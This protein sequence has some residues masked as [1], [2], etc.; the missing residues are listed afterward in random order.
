MIAQV[1]IPSQGLS[2][3]YYSPIWLALVLFVILFVAGNVLEG[4]EDE[5]SETVR[6]VGFL[7]ILLTGVYVLILF[8]VALTSEIDLVWDMVRIVVVVAVF[9]AALALLLLLVFER[10]IGGIS[11][12]RRRRRT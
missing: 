4:R 6:D 7:V 5:R 8:L 1:E 11:R 3:G 2:S 9:F 10:G 12:A